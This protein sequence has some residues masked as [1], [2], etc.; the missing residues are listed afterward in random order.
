MQFIRSFVISEFVM[1]LIKVV[2]YVCTYGKVN[3]VSGNIYCTNMFF[4]WQI[5]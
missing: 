4:A 2:K 1:Q 3:K 5:I